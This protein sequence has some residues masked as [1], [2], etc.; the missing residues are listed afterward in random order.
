[1]NAIILAA[2][3][4]QRFRDAG[5]VDPK[6]LLPMPDGRPL[7]TWVRERTSV[8]RAL[9]V[10]QAADAE[11]VRPWL[12]PDDALILQATPPRG[13]LDSALPAFARITGPTLL[14]YC[15]VLFDTT[16]FAQQA[17]ASGQAS[18]VVTFASSDPRYGYWNGVGV[19]EKVAVSNEAIFGVFYF[20]DAAA[21]VPRA[22]ALPDAAT[23]PDLLDA[24]TWRMPVAA[25][26]PD[27]GTPVEYEQFCVSIR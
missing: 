12:C 22:H 18:G 10:A 1:M 15:D 5:Y 16:A 2:G 23:I 17:H 11:R 9:V 20:R 19:T 14:V 25:R 3:A 26:P 13:Q 6:P 21:V 7:I 27:L 8:A 24:T 4:G